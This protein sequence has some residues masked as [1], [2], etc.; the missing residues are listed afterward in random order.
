VEYPK[1]VCEQGFVFCW[2]DVTLTKFY[3]VSSHFLYISLNT[4]SEQEGVIK[5]QLH[6]DYAPLASALYL[7]EIN[8]WR[9]I[10][11]KLNLIGQDDQRYGGLGY[12]NISQRVRTK[13]LQF[14][15]SG[16][17]TGHL[18]QLSHHDYCLIT[19]ASPQN[20]RIISIGD[21]QP[22]SE[23]L[24][25]ASVYAEVDT[26]Q[27]VIHVHSP[28]IWKNTH[29]LQLAHTPADIAYGTPAMAHAV[30]QL[31]DTQSWQHAA[32]FTMLG[33]ED[34][35]IAFGTSLTQAAQILIAQLALA[36]E[37]TML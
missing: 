32:V 1:R 11:Y 10:L 27:A 20:N 4:M 24:T 6:H 18:E 22:S 3:G 31:M 26:V 34:G 36:I 15:I 2:D 19:E 33:H 28:A 37:M 23:A 35:V 5:Y 25:H 7:A 9:S 16:T 29:T 17:Q 12:G 8:A 14:V 21:C 30:A 13:P